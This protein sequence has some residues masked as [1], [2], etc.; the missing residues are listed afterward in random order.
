[1]RV[2]LCAERCLC[3]I[4]PLPS[5]GHVKSPS[6]R[7]DEKRTNHSRGTRQGPPISVVHFRLPAAWTD[8]RNEDDQASG[9]NT[10]YVNLVLIV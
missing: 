5:M 4:P 8:T 9:R 1:M 6:R 10:R 3:E 7:F 2:T